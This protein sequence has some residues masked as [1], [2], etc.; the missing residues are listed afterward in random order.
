MQATHP[1]KNLIMKS[2]LL[3][4][5]FV[6]LSYTSKAVTWYVTF[7]GSG[8]QDA[9]SW[10][11]AAPGNNL[12][13]II[14]SAASGDEVW[15]A[16]GTYVPTS[17]NNRSIAFSMKNGV[18]IYGGF[19][20][21]E[22]TISDREFACGP[23]SI[24]S[25]DI[26]NAG[27]TDNS[28]NVVY[29]ELLDSTA[30]LDGFVIRDGNDDRSPSSAGNGLG[31]GIYN[32]GYGGA[33]YCHPI[34]RNCIFTNNFASWG[35]GAFNNGYQNGD[36]EPTYINCIFH[37]NHA[38]IEAGGM[39]SYGVGGN[40][41]PTVIN[42]L[43][44]ENTSATNVG[45]MYAWGGNNG[46]NSQPVLINC[47]FANNTANNGYGGAFIADNSDESGGT[48]SGSCTVTL[49]NC[50]VWNNSATGE[51]QQF[52]IRGNG[53]EVV[54]T[55]SD[56]DLSG[57][58]GPHV[59]SGAGT[60]NLNTDPLFINITNAIGLDSCW[61]TSDDG[62]QLQNSSPLIDAGN[63]SGA[64]NSDILGMAHVS[65]PDMG[66]YEFQPPSS[67]NES[68]TRHFFIS[69]NP[70]FNFITIQFTDDMPHSFEL[71][72]VHGKRLK[73]S[74]IIGKQVLDVQALESGVYFVTIDHST[75]ERFIKE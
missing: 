70:S 20:G 50:V 22:S 48:S 52:Y 12:Q 55:Y 15:V 19:E 34:I 10:L 17:T 21:T 25:G 11:N 56:I 9:T 38:Y 73:K 1:T 71:L 18:T 45:A 40:A 62:L 72:D 35:A 57:Q 66:A 46:G 2:L 41:S 7:S 63:A 69:P 28:F 67:I 54:A 4:A 51:G 3:I 16:C 64:P 39:D 13:M 61:L 53:A 26:G 14:D 36:T 47:V 42:T 30:I 74:V 32:H 58:S 8:S 65:N 49:Q 75:V 23:C 27:N 24:L 68:E 5:L 37:N 43:F 31:G 60:G 6:S 44:Y 29:N 59:I 33:G